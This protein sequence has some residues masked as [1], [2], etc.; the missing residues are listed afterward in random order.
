MVKGS[1]MSGRFG[2][3]LDTLSNQDAEYGVENNCEDKFSLKRERLR[4]EGNVSSWRCFVCKTHGLVM[5]AISETRMD[6][7]ECRRKLRATVAS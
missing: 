3:V 7:E 6:G 4:S 1:T 5:F 2:T